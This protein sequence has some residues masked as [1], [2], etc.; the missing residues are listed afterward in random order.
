MDLK[1]VFVINKDF[2]F[3]S[4]TCKLQWKEA[5]MVRPG[6][7]HF[8][9]KSLPHHP[10][11]ENLSY[12]AEMVQDVSASNPYPIPYVAEKVQMFLFPGL[13]PSVLW[14]SSLVVTDP[15]SVF[16]LTSQPTSEVFSILRMLS[17]MFTV[18]P[19]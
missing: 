14:G 2:R 5:I 4:R 17:S 15:L 10:D 12:V 3:A 6:Q 8:S 11:T 18:F 7:W 19:K 9:T 13:C 1:W 16:S